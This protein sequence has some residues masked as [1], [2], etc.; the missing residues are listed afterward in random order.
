MSKTYDAVVIGGGMEG[1]AN[2]YWLSKKGMK[3]VLLERGDILAGT[4]C[5]CDGNSYLCDTAPGQVTQTMKLAVKEFEK[6]AKEMD[7]DVD[8]IAKGMFTLCEDEEQF[9]LGIKQC[10]EK[11]ADGVKAR[12]VDS[13]ELH[14]AEPNLAKDI[15]GAIEFP[16]GCSVSPMLMAYGISLKIK[17]QGGEIKPYSEVIGI[18]LDENGAVSKVITPEEE[19]FTQNV[20]NCAG[21]WS[22]S[23]GNMV[24][25]DIPV[26]MMKGD[27]LVTESDVV[28]NN[29]YVCEIGYNLLRND[30]KLSNA[31]AIRQKYGIGFLMEPT[32]ANNYV[33]GF[34]KYP[35]KDF[36][37][38]VEVT[39]AIAGRAIRFYPMMKDVNL[40]RAFAGLRPWTP[41]HEPIISKTK[42]KGFWVC[43]GHCGSGIT[44]SVL[45]GKLIS[46]MIFGENTDI[47]M[48]R[49]S[50]DRFYK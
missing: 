37:T 36:V 34:S 25:V 38:N 3:V 15:Y 20:V 47:A 14:E 49:Y 21:A 44:Y 6:L 43:S 35:G 13:K 48:D 4:S 5:R 45:S 33:V 24:G 40:I 7:I 32:G 11:I 46:Q 42:V 31:D 9:E 27:L 26:T 28:I 39:R 50:L 41:D 12:M 16:E 1:L 29:R 8:Y 18:D 10:E 22:S 23:I 2:A 30:Q 17:Q 19:Y